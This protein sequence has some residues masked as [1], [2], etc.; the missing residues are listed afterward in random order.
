MLLK[1]IRLI[2]IHLNYCLMIDDA[3]IEIPLELTEVLDM[4]GSAKRVEFNNVIFSPKKYSNDEYVIYYQAKVNN[5]I[6]R[7]NNDT[8]TIINSFHL[9]KLKQLMLMF[10]ML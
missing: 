8:L 6:F 4:S 9:I 7:I 5:L 10:V 1:A 2:N 3:K